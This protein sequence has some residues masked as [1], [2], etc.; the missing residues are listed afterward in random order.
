MEKQSLLAIKQNKLLRNV[1][2]SL[3]DFSKIKGRLKTLNQGA[4][5]FREGYK[6]DSVFLIISGEI[7]IIKK[8]LFG[9]TQSFIFN[10]ADY[11]GYKEI[12][13]GG[14]RTST[15]VALRDAY[16]IEL[17]LEEIGSLMSQSNQIGINLQSV[18]KD[19]T[20]NKPSEDKPKDQEN[21]KS[22]E[23]ESWTKLNE[24][25]DFETEQLNSL[26]EEQTNEE[27]IST[28]NFDFVDE[29]LEG[30]KI[31]Q[32]GPG[33]F[34]ITED[35]DDDEDH[36][37][38]DEPKDNSE[39]GKIADA[40]DEIPKEVYNGNANK[41]YKP[42]EE[43]NDEH[44]F[45][46]EDEAFFAGLEN[47]PTQQITGDEF[48]PS[49]ESKEDKKID[50]EIDL[51]LDSRFSLDDEYPTE[52]IKEEVL[53]E[54]FFDGEKSE[55]SEETFPSEEASQ[56]P[57]ETVSKGEDKPV[58]NKELSSDQLRMINKA[59]QSITSN[60]KIEEVLNNIVEAACELTKADRGTLYLVDK[61]SN[62]LW[63]KI[64]TESEV[65]EIRLGIGEGIAG[66]V[67]KSGEIVNIKNAEEDHRFKRDYDRSSGYKTKSML[68]FPLKNKEEKIVGVIQLLNS[69][70]GFFSNL[71]E[72]FLGALSAHASAALI[73]AELV[74]KLLKSERVT[75]LG[76]MAN[77][78]IQDIKKPVL[79]SKR[80]A[81]HLIAKELPK[82]AKQV[83]EMMLEQLNHVADI[84]QTTSSYSEGKSVLR[85]VNT[86]LNEV[87]DDYINRIDTYLR[88]K[89]CTITTQFDLDVNVKIDLKEFFQCFNHIVKNACEAMPDGGSIL[90]STERKENV[91]NISIK[92]NGLGI[93]DTIIDKIFD[94]FMTHGKKEGTG[95]GLSI[96]KK[97]IEDHSGS[98]SVH[99][100][101]GEG[102]TFVVSLPI[103]SSF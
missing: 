95:L 14:I 4:I 72:Q 96:T 92:D 1:D 16:L 55:L 13:D 70:N 33:E 10:D 15:A 50:D 51:N 6:A 7:N 62:E 90:I 18:E 80:Y 32:T 40:H 57:E 74:E 35:L 31:R 8:N 63:S 103:V 26:E 60:V 53:E 66:W 91:V 17:T 25:I 24:E 89:N 44:N 101:L 52:I 28:E 2:D 78:L 82:D 11:F 69:A 87:L 99:S 27:K 102:T 76:K 73:N 20:A 22:I 42:N 36:F 84:V 88:N 56:S 93:P 85:A 83:L 43:Q 30:M 54:D 48:V 19:L 21:N 12:S 49:E 9:K 34:E 71:D 100:D 64:V 58:I 86:S 23:D 79:V 37:H 47:D 65:K 45:S 67:A 68:C 97:I 94:P 98:I 39:V 77:F 38:H 61:E 81:E 5:L 3:I 41:N 59:A 75:S 29:E 46:E